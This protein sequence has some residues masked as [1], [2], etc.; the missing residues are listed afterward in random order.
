MSASL[1]SDNVT[2][3]YV[4]LGSNLRAEQ[5]LTLA[6]SALIR[7]FGSI[8]TSS[9]YTTAAMPNSAQREDHHS[10]P[11]ADYLNMVARFQSDEN[12]EKL[13][14]TLRAI[15]ARAGERVAGHCPLDIDV[16][17]YGDLIT[18]ENGFDIPRRDIQDYAYVA[19]PL[20]E[21]APDQRHPESGQ[22]F[23]WYAAQHEHSDQ[24]VTRLEGI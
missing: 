18:H 9:V 4:G 23:A 14:A 19:I 24:R 3:I 15:E 8:E 12:L 13:K 11:A 21:L 5:N 22:P 16:L 2:E 6:I 17:L 7:A 1:L 10:E 20:A